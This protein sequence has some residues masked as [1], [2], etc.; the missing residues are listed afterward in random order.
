MLRYVG[1]IM[2]VEERVFEV[3][4]V[5]YGVDIEIVLLWMGGIIDLICC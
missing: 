1:V 4:V 5:V 3:G 2:E